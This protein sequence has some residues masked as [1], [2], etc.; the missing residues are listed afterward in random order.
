M[1][2]TIRRFCHSL[3]MFLACAGASQATLAEAPAPDP[4][5]AQYEVRFMS[6]MID[7]H[8]MAVMMGMMCVERAIH[9]EL[10]T[11]CQDIVSNQSEEIKT[12]QAWLQDWYDLSHEPDMNMDAMKDHDT[13]YGADF[14]VAFLKMM[15]RHHA[16]AVR[17]GSRC[18]EMASHPDLVSMCSDIVESQ[19]QEIRTMRRW[20]CNWY[21]ICRSNFGGLG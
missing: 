1:Q 19:L 4:A 6:T 12:M 16:K 10:A 8:H 13:L 9:A 5:T 11:M 2:S 3:L 15:I 18:I 17:E 20:L 7:H 14:E 21:A